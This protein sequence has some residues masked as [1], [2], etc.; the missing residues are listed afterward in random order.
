M[1][2]KYKH[3]LQDKNIQRWFDNVGRG[4]KITA[5]VYFRRL[6]YFCL[7]NHTSPRQLIKLEDKK[8]YDL[9]LDAVSDFEKKKLSGGYIA[10]VLKSV[11][12]WLSFNGKVVTRR[13]QIRGAQDTPTLRNER[14]PTQEEL[15]KVFL[16]GDERARLATALIAHAGV[17]PEVVGNYDGTDGLTVGD[18]PDLELVDGSV[19]FKTVPAMVR[20]RAG[21]SKK[22]NEYFTF[23]TAEACEFLKDYLELR[24]RSGEKL[25]LE[26]AVVIPYSKRKFIS[27]TRI[28]AKIKRAIRKAGFEWRPYVLRAYFATQL[29]V[30]E[31]KGLIIRDYRTF[32]MGHKGDIEHT[33][34]L[35]KTRLPP[36]VIEQMREGYRG[37]QRYLQTRDS[38]KGDGDIKRMFKRQLLLVAGFSSDEITE[39]HLV[40]G[41]DEFQRVVR[42]RLTV[43]M[44][45]NGARQKVV[46]MAE[47]ESH[48]REGWEYVGI[49]PG[50]K[51]IL[52]LP[53]FS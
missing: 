27:T 34:T 43:Q 46:P 16:A 37:A 48:L 39:D 49:L 28:C 29:M 30:A 6:G 9:L 52:R 26:S 2:P 33:Y 5:M 10:S 18:F 20:V 53:D 50:D 12:S 35:N 42:E 19:R 22:R 45:N 13:I 32:F 44:A 40:L 23:L 47:V 14:V 8:L 1:E 7:L 17:R 31:S 15:G 25:T 36:E 24:M 38:E 11:K 51:A 41:D 3:L 21:L 4:S